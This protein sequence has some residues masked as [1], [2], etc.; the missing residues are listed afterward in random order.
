[1]QTQLKKAQGHAKSAKA[2]REKAVHCGVKLE[3]VSRS[4]RAQEKVE[5]LDLLVAGLRSQLSGAQ[6]YARSA[7]AA[8][9][10]AH[11]QAQE[12]AAAVVGAVATLSELRACKAKVKTLEVRL[13]Q[14]QGATALAQANRRRD[15]SR[16][17]QVGRS[18][19][20]SNYVVCVNYN[21]KSNLR[22]SGITALTLFYSIV[23]FTAVNA[24]LQRDFTRKSHHR[25]GDT[26]LEAKF[27]AQRVAFEKYKVW[28]ARG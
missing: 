14:A 19:F 7:E 6:E 24:T 16:L 5:E 3:T 10:K 13:A 9:Q 1:M 28:C 27:E 4:L 17:G 23:R 11:A 22:F 25:L 18:G 20:T 8:R 15:R 2:A 21:L 12:Q 26:H